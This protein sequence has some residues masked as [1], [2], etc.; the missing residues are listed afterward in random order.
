MAN[1]AQNSHNEKANGHAN[2][3]SA[4]EENQQ[5]RSRRGITLSNFLIF[6]F[7]SV[8]LV[9]IGL[10]INYHTKGGH[11]AAVLALRWGIIGYVL[12]GVGL[13]FAYYEYVV[14]PARLAAYA[15][16]EPRTK[17]RF[18]A[19]VEAVIGQ[20]KRDMNSTYW[21]A[22][23]GSIF[24][25]H[26]ALFLRF[27]NDGPP[28]MIESYRVEALNSK[29]MWVTLYRI[30]NLGGE[31]DSFYWVS[32]GQ[33][34]KAKR[35]EA[36]SIDPQ[37]IN[38]VIPSHDVVRGWAYFELPEDLEIDRGAKLRIQIKDV[39]GDESIQEVLVQG[40]GSKGSDL[41]IPIRMSH[42]ET[43]LS[44]Y[45]KEYLSEYKGGSAETL[46]PTAKPKAPKNP[47]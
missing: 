22:F 10:A 7:G 19:A 9:F 1:S 45:R 38:R 35:W 30:P 6:A 21:F 32:S 11:D 4:K 12:F 42:D 31:Y 3:K 40:M 34:D 46:T 43:D 41:Q 33:F 39:T 18:P 5:A 26:I 36:S 27:V 23:A 15:A 8:G 20:S 16:I 14:K 25:A 44:G 17:E 2:T 37:L 47:N 29:G 24:P 28:A 13:Y